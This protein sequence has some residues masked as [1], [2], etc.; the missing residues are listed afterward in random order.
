[1]NPL[2]EHISEIAQNEF[3]LGEDSL[4]GIDHWNEVYKNGIMLSKQKGVDPL[5]VSLFAFIHDCKREDDDEDWG[6][7]ERAA[8]FVWKLISE[9]ILSTLSSSQIPLLVEACAH[10]NKGVINKENITI[11]ACYDAD[12]LELVRCDIIPDPKLMSTEIGI[13]I[14]EEMQKMENN[15]LN[16][17]SEV[18]ENKEMTETD[19]LVRNWVHSY[20]ESISQ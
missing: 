10:H 14:A 1:M 5:V 15:P 18:V 17:F 7:G 2:V 12:R 9:G 13:R 16:Y 8:R 20:K 11:G 3:I 19:I 6:H 4:H